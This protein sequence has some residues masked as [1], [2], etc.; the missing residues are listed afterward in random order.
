MSPLPPRWAASPHDGACHALDV[1][2]AV[3]AL[4]RGWVDALC[5]HT[6]P[7]AALVITD[8]PSGLLCG[9]CA[10]RAADGLPGP[11]LR[12][13]LGMEIAF[14]RARR[15]ERRTARVVWA[16]SHSGRHGA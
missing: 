16:H 10:A 9:P 11:G 5:T 15:A 12:E 8:A 13:W 2:R 1:T 3:E 4:A 14:C 7:A 6:M